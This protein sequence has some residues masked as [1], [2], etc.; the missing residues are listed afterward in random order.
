V[1][2]YYKYVHNEDYTIGEPV[3]C[4][5]GHEVVWRNPHDG[6]SGEPQGRANV[7]TGRL[8]EVEVADEDTVDTRF[9]IF[10]SESEAWCRRYTVIAEHPDPLGPQT[11]AVRD[12][13]RELPAW[14]WLKPSFSSVDALVNLARLAS[15][16]FCDCVH[17]EFGVDV[18]R[19]RRL[20]NFAWL[21]AWCNVH[22][23]DAVAAQAAN[24]QLVYRAV[25]HAA[26]R[27]AHTCVRPLYQSL[28]RPVAM[29][30]GQLAAGLAMA[31][32]VPQSPI[33]TGLGALLKMGCWSVGVEDT[34]LDGPLPSSPKFFLWAGDDLAGR[35]IPWEAKS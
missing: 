7:E 18:E 17:F 23:A 6:L 14:P 9:A 28:A 8:L 15:G 33:V 22:R 29:D 3:T 12:L 24:R 1:A 27:K 31:D 20:M 32:L 25:Y 35:E 10:E 16:G 34:E 4:R 13:L 26:W 2:R 30:V 19:G 5:G 11:V 21:K